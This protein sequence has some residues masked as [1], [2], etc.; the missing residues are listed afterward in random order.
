MD[1]VKEI[2]PQKRLKKDNRRE[3]TRRKSK[4]IK[5][6]KQQVQNLNNRGNH[7]Q[8]NLPELKDTHCQVDSIH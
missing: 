8:K 1:K 6:A 3:K 2:S 4:Q 7:Q 5:G